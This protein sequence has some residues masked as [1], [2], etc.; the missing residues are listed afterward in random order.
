MHF[1]WYD[2]ETSGRDPA[3]DRPIQI[4]WQRT[5]A[6][7]QPITEAESR[8]IRLPDDVL[9]SP[10]AMMVHQILPEVHQRHGMSEAELAVLLDELISSNTWVAGYNS[11]AFDD[12]FT[13]HVFFRSLRDPYRWQYAQGRGRFDL[14]PV[15]LSFFVFHPE[16]ILWPEDA[17]GRPR[18]KLDRLGPLNGLDQ[19]IERAHDAASDVAMTARLAERLARE[20]PDLFQEALNRTDKHQ[21]TELIRSEGR[22][23]GLLE[24]T[25][26]A[27]WSQGYARDVW[28]PFRLTEKSNDYVAFDLNQDPDDVLSALGDAVQ[29]ADPIEQRKQVRAIGA[30]T[31]RINAQPMLFRRDQLH[32]DTLK[33]LADY[34]RDVQRQQGHLDRWHQIQGSD[35][36]KTLY[37]QAL[38]LFSEHT[39]VSEI[40]DVDGS[41]YRGGFPSDHDRNCLESAPLMDPEAL[42]I[43][44]PRFDDPRYGELVFRYR[45]RNF[46]ESLTPV[47]WKRWQSIRRQKLTGSGPGVTIETLQAEL[48]AL[49]DQALDSHHFDQLRQFSAWLDN[50]PPV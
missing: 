35:L 1:L 41:L 19:G 40:G 3:F 27:G 45:A 22:S 34:G 33:R 7:C 23:H 37:Q 42:K 5:D 49:G 26:F 10:G 43:W 48:I 18:F 25:P 17:D 20:N 47:E 36:F 44:M 24:V 31:V 11:R 39:D 30:Y 2:Y 14:Y 8:Y 50:Q 15:V 12:R 4:G 13:Q 21:V 9:P 28:I 38:L 29:I 46:P 6:A 16:A 32:P